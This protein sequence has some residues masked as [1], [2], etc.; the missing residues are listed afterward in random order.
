MDNDG[1]QIVSYGKKKVKKPNRPSQRKRKRIQK[2][3]EEIKR[4]APPPPLPTVAK[5]SYTGTI[6][7]G[8]WDEL[9]AARQAER[10]GRDPEE[11]LVN[12]RYFSGVYE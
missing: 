9:M 4:R 5:K 8:D 10:E 6:V 3:A 12:M 7:C 1:W 2:A 11:A